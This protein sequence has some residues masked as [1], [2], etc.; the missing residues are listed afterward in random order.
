VRKKKLKLFLLSFILPQ[1]EKAKAFSRKEKQSFSLRG[2]IFYPSSRTS[3]A[4]EKNERTS[5]A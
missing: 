5:F 2:P 3:E 1:K 4:C